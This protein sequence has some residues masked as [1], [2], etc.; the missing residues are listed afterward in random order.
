MTPAPAD[1][2]DSGPKA[3]IDSRNPLGVA[4]GK[5]PVSP[6]VSLL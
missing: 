3:R 1:S 4:S 5:L 6:S 2:A